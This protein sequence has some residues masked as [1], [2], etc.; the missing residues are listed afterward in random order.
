[1]GQPGDQQGTNA[2]LA[3]FRYL[4]SGIMKLMPFSGNAEEQAA[5]AP[6]N[7]LM[8][9]IGNEGQGN[10]NTWL[11]RMVS[12][13][14]TNHYRSIYSFQIRRHSTLESNLDEEKEA[15]ISQVDDVV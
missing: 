1:M 2:F 6:E 9:R 11:S 8:T 15:L 10:W 5:P 4:A 14:E 12:T 7:I 13:Q 3:N